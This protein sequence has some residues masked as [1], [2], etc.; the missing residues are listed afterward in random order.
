[1]EEDKLAIKS[2]I[3]TEA[4]KLFR[5]YGVKSVTMDD[6]A[7]QM[8]ISK[9]TIYQHLQDKDELV[10]IL[11]EARITTHECGLAKNA[12]LGEDA[13]HE[14]FLSLAEV[15]VWLTTFNRKLFYDLQKYYP[16]AWARLRDFKEKSLAKTISR[17]LKRGLGEGIYRK[18]MNIDVLTGLRLSHTQMLLNTEG[19]YGRHSYSIAQVAEEVTTHYLYG[20]CNTKGIKLIEKYKQLTEK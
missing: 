20:I 12:K 14:V 7:K 9:R 5:K 19:Q 3:I 15:N 1:M 6:I 2:H 11:L 18:D 8:G 17:N 13:V 16:A 4:G 10:N